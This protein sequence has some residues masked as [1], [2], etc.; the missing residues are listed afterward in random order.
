MPTTTKM[1]IVYPS[2]TDLV[3]DGATAMGTISTTVD[4]KT[5]MVLL[6]T[7]AF[8]ATSQQIV[9]NVFSTNFDNYKIIVNVTA[10]SG[11]TL[12]TYTRFGT[13]GTSNTNAS[14][15][16]NGYYIDTSTPQALNVPNNTFIYSSL[17]AAGNTNTLSFDLDIF[18]PFATQLTNFIGSS[19]EA[20]GRATTIYGTF[21][22]TTSF[23]DV[24][25]YPSANN[26][27]GTISVYGYN[28]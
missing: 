3:K 17:K 27:T 13:S 20:S 22:A 18:N 2:S 8:S 9:T 24:V 4:A 1:G 25:I 14:Y 15:D 12:G 23:T 28:K 6:N 26:M 19:T 21:D 10:F 5:G 11:N 16:N 7:T